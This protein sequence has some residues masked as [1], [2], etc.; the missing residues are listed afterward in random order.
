MTM[1]AALLFDVDDTLVDTSPSYRRAAVLTAEAYGVRVTLDDVSAAKAAGDANDD[2]LLTQRLIV[3]RGAAAEYDEVKR[4]FEELYQ[5]TATRRGLK[6]DETLLVTRDALEK[7]SRRFALGIVT[8]RPL[9]DALELLDR[10]DLRAVF[11][12]VVTMDDGPLKP[13]PA[14]IRLALDRVGTARAW[15]I[16]DTPDDVRA[17]RAAGIPAIGVV[18]KADEPKRARAALLGAGAAHVLADLAE[19]DALLADAAASGDAR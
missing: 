2:W 11:S 16:G 15:M 8:G 10:Y 19:L 4:V 14:P 17:A 12:A 18:A 6:H 13:D 9:V 7:W 5:G 3:S 1:P